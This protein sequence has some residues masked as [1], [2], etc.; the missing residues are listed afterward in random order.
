MRARTAFQSAGYRALF[1]GRIGIS[2]ITVPAR[3]VTKRRRRC[4]RHAPCAAG[5][6]G[7]PPGLIRGEFRLP[8]LRVKLKIYH[9][10]GLLHLQQFDTG[11]PRCGPFKLM[12]GSTPESPT[13]APSIFPFCNRRVGGRRCHFYI[14]N[15]TAEHC[16][17]SRYPNQYRPLRPVRWSPP[18][19]SG[20]K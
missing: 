17:D 12:P 6:N 19:S 4:V 11:K 13:I 20:P 16:A 8:C 9:E 3:G 1:S 7:Q 10:C 15:G 18:A 5:L 14:R 2:E